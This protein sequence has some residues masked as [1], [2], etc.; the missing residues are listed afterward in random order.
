[1]GHTPR[2]VFSSAISTSL[3]FS[4]VESTCGAFEALAGIPEAIVSKTLEKDAVRSAICVYTG[5]LD[6]IYLVTG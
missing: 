4:L 6:Q 1:M 2:G 5:L 3:D